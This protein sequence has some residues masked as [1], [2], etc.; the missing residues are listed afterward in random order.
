MRD[1]VILMEK[2]AKIEFSPESFRL[3]CEGKEIERS[4]RK[5]S[6]MQE[7]SSDKAFFKKSGLEAGKAIYHM[8][9]EVRSLGKIRYDITV[10]PAFSIGNEFV[11]T[12]GHY[13]PE[14]KPGLGFC[15]IY[16]VLQGNA[17]YMLQ[18][19]ENGKVIEVALVKATEGDVVVIPP[20]WGHV[21]INPGKKTLVMANLVDCSFDSDYS[22]YK[23]MGGAAYFEMCDGKLFE[24]R[25][26]QGAPKIRI[27]D[28]ESFGKG[29]QAYGKLKGKNLL[30][31]MKKEGKII[32]F[33]SDPVLL[34]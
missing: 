30:E 18:R 27:C 1:N 10:I 29:L 6:E 20:N 16:Q 7:V 22:V 21:T 26:Y 31:V 3:Y 4:V 25:K 14:A 24:N 23:K 34:R 12:A 8:Y 9:R 19:R 33:L 11:K 15:E 5:L 13:H 2:P 32:E 17:H 28:A